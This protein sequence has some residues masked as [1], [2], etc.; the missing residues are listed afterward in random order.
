M[1]TEVDRLQVLYEVNDSEF[2][3]SMKRMQNQSNT[4]NA[5]IVNQAKKAENAA[6][7]MSSAWFKASTAIAAAMAAIKLATSKFTD[8]YK[9]V[10]NQLSSIGQS[11]NVATDKLYAAAN[12]AMAQ[13]T[14]FATTVQRIQKATG[15]GYDTTIRRVETLQKLMQVGGLDASTADSVVTQ[16]SQ[17]LQSGVLQGDEFRSLREGAPVELLDAIA[18]AAGTTRDRLKDFAADG[19]L[20]SEVVLTAIDSMSQQA[21][22]AFGNLQVTVEGASTR[23]WNSMQQIIGAFDQGAGASGALAEK[24]SELAGYLSSLADASRSAGEEVAAYGAAFWALNDA[25]GG[26]QNYIP[27]VFNLY[28]AF[29]T[30]ADGVQLVQDGIGF[31]GDKFGDTSALGEAFFSGLL[32]GVK[33][34]VGAMT[35]AA[36]VIG[37][38]FF[39]IVDGV[40]GSVTAIMN[41]LLE[42]IESWINLLMDG[43]RKIAS[44]SDSLSGSVG[45]WFGKEGTNLAAS[46]GTVK[47]GRIGGSGT[48][49]SKGSYGQAYKDGYDLGSGAVDSALDSAKAVIDATQQAYEDKKSE[50]EGLKREATENTKDNDMSAPVNKTTTTTSDDKSDK[51][52]KGSGSKGRKNKFSVESVIADMDADTKMIDAQRESLGWTTEALATYMAKREALAELEKRGIPYSE[53]QKKKIEESAEAYGKATAALE[54]NQMTQQAYDTAI[55][56][57]ADGIASVILEGENLGDVLG[58]VFKQ[59]AS[60]L[61]SSGL[62]TLLKNLFG[63]S[64]TGSVAGNFFGSLFGGLFGGARANGGSVT[65]G[66]AYVVGE[67]RPELF[68]PSTNGTIIPSTD[69]QTTQNSRQSNVGVQVVPSPYFDVVVQEIAD[70]SSQQVGAAVVK[71]MPEHIKSYEQNRRK[72]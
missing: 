39:S 71:S 47:L 56:G 21:D 51:K 14:N 13:A 44:M 2:I 59:L 31:I 60:D 65:A 32:Q 64:P 46:V 68:V 16:L 41:Q 30:V 62:L 69:V 55:Q 66:N 25:L 28:A 49:L 63:G 7:L 26:I 5:A 24:M 33:D 48:N 37:E 54:A 22:K 58:N 67:K 11:S 17:A 70:K 27:D 50:I 3:L 23:V 43:I 15:D 57:L 36:S 61:L 34:L 20:T 6:S 8:P 38:A 9:E 40:T 45:K 72:R 12:R 19:K 42:A 29:E 4:T 53:A 10:Q 1:P 35:G 52:K 18:K